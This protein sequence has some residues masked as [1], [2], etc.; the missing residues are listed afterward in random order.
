MLGKF[1][2]SVKTSTEWEKLLDILLQT[3]EEVNQAR[4][5]AVRVLCHYTVFVSESDSI[6]GNCGHGSID[7]LHQVR[8]PHCRERWIFSATTYP[9]P[10]TLEGSAEAMRALL[11][12]SI[13]YIGYV[14]ASGVREPYLPETVW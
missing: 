10:Q 4:I 5:N 13:V 8:C 6:C 14:D 11:P 3:L 12:S 7:P 2:Q 9:P 1:W